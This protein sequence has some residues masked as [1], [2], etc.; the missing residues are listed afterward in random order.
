MRKP[1][2]QARTEWFESETTAYFFALVTQAKNAAK[3]ALQDQGF[4]TVSAEQLQSLRGNLWGIRSTFE[5]IEQ[6][7]L[8]QSFSQLEEEDEEHVGNSPE[9]GSDIDPAGGDRGED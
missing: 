1:T 3:E 2:N 4:D 5:D 6:V 8:S 9:G 7:F